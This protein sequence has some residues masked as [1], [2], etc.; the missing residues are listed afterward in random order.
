MQETGQLLYNLDFFSLVIIMF[1]YNFMGWFYESTLYSIIEQ[2]RFMNRGYFL[3]PYCPI[4]GVVCISG[5]YF[6]QDIS[7]HIKIMLMGALL[8]TAI[9][10]ITSYT[11]EKLFDARYWDYSAYPLNINGRVSVVSSIF[12]GFATMFVVTV[13]QPIMEELVGR[14]SEDIRIVTAVSILIIFVTDGVFTTIS[15]CNL[16]KK[17]KDIYDYLDEFV[18]GKFEAITDKSKF[19]DENL[20][21]EKKKEISVALKNVYNNKKLPS[22]KGVKQLKERGAIKDIVSLKEKGNFLLPTKIFKETELHFFRA[23][24]Y[25]KS[26]KYSDLVEKIKKIQRDKK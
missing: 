15:M 1:T 5:V 24:P 14:M 17:F 22:L 21:I 25:F 26:T 20:I 8:V 13:L 2:K 23:F 4:Y 16:N 10:Y 7:S 19:L 12:F 9:E 3:G 18:D 11:L 6:L